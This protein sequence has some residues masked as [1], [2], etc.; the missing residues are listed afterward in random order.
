M[1]TAEEIEGSDEIKFMISEI[2]KSG[3]SGNYSR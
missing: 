2:N 1:I 3:Y